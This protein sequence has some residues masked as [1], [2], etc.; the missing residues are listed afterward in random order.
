[1][2]PISQRSSAS[3]VLSLRAQLMKGLSPPHIQDK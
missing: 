3:I 2:P 1:M